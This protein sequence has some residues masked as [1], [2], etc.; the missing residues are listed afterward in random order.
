MD[1]AEID[2][3]EALMRYLCIRVLETVVHL[4]DSVILLPHY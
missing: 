2:R 1:H 4:L 3:T